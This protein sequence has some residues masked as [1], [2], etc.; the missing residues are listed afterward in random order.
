MAV[1]SEGATAASTKVGKVKI[2]V[3]GESDEQP[4]SP[5]VTR[6]MDLGPPSDSDRRYW[7]AAESAAVVGASPPGVAASSAPTIAIDEAPLGAI[8][9]AGLRFVPHASSVPKNISPQFTEPIPTTSLSTAA[10]SS[11]HFELSPQPP[12]QEIPVASSRR[13]LDRSMRIRMSGGTGAATGKACIS[14]QN[15]GLLPMP[16]APPVPVPKVPPVPIGDRPP[17]DSPP[18]PTPDA[19]ATATASTPRPHAIE[20]MMSARRTG[21]HPFV[22]TS[23]SVDDSFREIVCTLARS[24][25]N[26]AKIREAVR[27]K[28]VFLHDGLDLLPILAHGQDDPSV[29]R[30]F[31]ARD[32]EMS[33][34]VILVQKRDVRGHVR[35]DFGEVDLVRELD[36]EHRR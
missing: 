2:A 12:G 32:E 28:R 23:A 24:E 8:A 16:T 21:V 33:G 4:D 34:S 31:S 10:V 13:E 6:R 1:V 9:T 26:D 20:T 27:V 22:D 15:G 30:D 7:T 18:Q 19:I 25:L 35:V 29:P 11:A 17:S 14:P 5:S 36:D 3:A